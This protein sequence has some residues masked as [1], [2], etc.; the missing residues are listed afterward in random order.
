MKKVDEAVE[1]YLIDRYELL[2]NEFLSISNN[3]DKFELLKEMKNLSILLYE[4]FGI[5][6]EELK[7]R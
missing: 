2:K 1:K 4:K 5:Y 7:F 6:T 3:D